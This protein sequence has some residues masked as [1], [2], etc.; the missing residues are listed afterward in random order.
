MKPR[1]DAGCVAARLVVRDEQRQCLA[2]GPH[3]MHGSAHQCA[4]K[5]PPC[6][7]RPPPRQFSVPGPHAPV[8]RH[9]RSSAGHARRICAP[10]PHAPI[11]RHT[12]S[13]AARPTAREFSCQD[14][15][16]LFATTPAAARGT[17]A[18]FSHQDPMHLFAATPGAA[19]G[20]RAGFSHQD[21]MHLFAAT[22]GAALGMR[23][24]FSHQDPM[25]QFEA[26]PATR[27][28]RQPRPLAPIPSRA[29][30]AEVM[31]REPARVRLRRH[32]GGCR[33]LGCLPGH[34]LPGHCLS[35]PT[36]FPT[37]AFPATACPAIDNVNRV[38]QSQREPGIPIF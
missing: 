29:L 30:P 22:P 2:R 15:M 35:R 24:E 19:L 9:T 17:R 3:R 34:R 1:T 37:T 8:R 23:A 11:R 20:T 27:I 13:G 12:R 25:H 31:H 16:H 4:D 28:L 14:P 38:P 18:E 26:A 32:T 7:R 6:P 10:G 33:H 36:A 5:A 21:P